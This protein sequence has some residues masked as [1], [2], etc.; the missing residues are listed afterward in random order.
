VKPKLKPPGTK[1]LKLNCD[2]L[3]ST[4]AFKFN[5]RRYTVD[6]SILHK[7][8]HGELVESKNWLPSG[9][10]VIGVTSGASTPDKVGPL[11]RHPF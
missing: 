6:N 8:A 1:R 7:L 4:S 10:V 2:I 11:T 5:L 9:P 3:L